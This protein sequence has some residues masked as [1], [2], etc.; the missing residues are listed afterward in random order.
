MERVIEVLLE[1]LE[2]GE[3]V[4]LAAV[5]GRVGSIPTPVGARLLVTVEG[6]ARGT[7]G[8][9]SLEAGAIRAAAEA[10]RR[11]ESRVD[12]YDFSNARAGAEGMLCGGRVEVLT[13]LVPP[14]ELELFCLLRRQLSGGAGAWLVSAIRPGRGG[15]P[16]GSRLL[17]DREGRVLAGGL[18]DLT[19]PVRTALAPR[20]DREDPLV[21]ELE[22]PPA[23]DQSL[24]GFLAEPLASAPRLVIFGGGHIAMPLC[25]VAALCG[26]RPTVVDDRP[27]F[28]SP[29]R[30]PEAEAVLTCGSAEAFDRLAIGPSHYLVS[31]T[32]GHAH[33]GEVIRR[34]ILTPAAYVGMIGSHRKV[35]LLWEELA[36]QGADPQRLAL[37]RAPVGLE[38]GA[39]TPEEIA[40]SIVAQLIAVRRGRSPELGRVVL[41]H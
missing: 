24:R 3:P 39:E 38:I 33:D 29:E 41:G 34:A 35:K 12:S 25:R 7:L 37:V 36:R 40:V 28:S 15:D 14:A 8:G 2:R 27:E 30:F 1:R 31:V 6:L 4:A 22:Q 32:R 9:G 20:R 10:L 11:G 26:F 18:G 5:I 19:E 17:L 16:R 23:G 21:L 13:E